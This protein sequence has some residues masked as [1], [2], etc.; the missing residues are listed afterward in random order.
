MDLE[1]LIAQWS[2]KLPEG[3]V[4]PAALRRTPTQECS[5]MRCHR[6]VAIKKD[7][8]PAKACERCLA[9]RAASCRRR[10]AALVAEG[11]CR[12]CSYRK[13]AEGD[14]LCP[15]CREDR[16]IERA[17]KRRDAIEAAIVDEFA[18]KPDSVHRASNMDRGIS[19]WNA[20]PRPEPSA[21]YWSPLPDP[22]PREEREWA[23][24]IHDTGWRLSR[25]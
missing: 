3:F 7:G 25:H 4:P 5:H 10:R 15:R 1:L 16:E 12:R 21:A 14:F 19:P 2:G 24:S 11:G 20:S 8:T 13:R 22:E 6:P 18:A 17:H 9:R 23:H